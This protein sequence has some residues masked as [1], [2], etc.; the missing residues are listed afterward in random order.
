MMR[1][2][3]AVLAAVVALA[4]ADA[5]A[6]EPLPWARG[7]LAPAAE[8]R[9]APSPEVTRLVFGVGLNYFVARGFSLGLALSD[10]LLVYANNT[11]ARLPT[12][13]EQ[14]PTNMVHLT[15]NARWT[16]FRRF[17]FSPYVY[18]GLG[19]TFFNNNRGIIGHWEAGPGAYVGLVGGLFL[20]LGVVFSGNFPLEQCKGAYLYQ[21]PD[22]RAEPIQKGE[23][24]FSWAP[25][26]GIA[27]AFGFGKVRKKA[28]QSENDL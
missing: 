14:V 8:G 15:P 25:K 24:A 1:T 23:C 7:T 19:P 22:A 16:F 18:T 3:S 4:A 2:G 21:P 13:D 11:R 5:R 17:R 9:V 12:L 20:D 26:I 6:E 10:E 27:Y 28:Q